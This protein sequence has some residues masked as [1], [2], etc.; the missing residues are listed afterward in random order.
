MLF[1][2]FLKFVFIVL[3]LEQ[4]H[5][6]SWRRCV[7]RFTKIVKAFWRKT[8]APR[9]IAST[10]CWCENRWRQTSPY[11]ITKLRLKENRWPIKRKVEDAGF[12]HC[13]TQWEF[14]LWKNLKLRSLS[15]ARHTFSTGIRY[16]TIFI[17]KNKNKQIN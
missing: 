16:N 12:L 4:C 2:N 14:L 17:I 9:A 8:S 11:S 10:L 5:R 3:Q 6:T 7:K 15:S 1:C 13:S